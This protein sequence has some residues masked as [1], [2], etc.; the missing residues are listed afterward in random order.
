[1]ARAACQRHQLIDL[2]VEPG[3]PS[4]T[5]MR[6]RCGQ[7]GAYPRDR[8]GGIG[9]AANA[10]QRPRS[11][12][13]RAR[14]TN[15]GSPPADRP[16]RTAASGS[17]SAGRASPADAPRSRR[18]VHSAASW[19]HVR[20]SPTLRLPQRS[21]ND[22]DARGGHAPTAY[23]P[24]CRPRRGGRRRRDGCVANDAGL[25]RQLSR[26]CDTSLTRPWSACYVTPGT[27]GVQRLVVVVGKVTMRT[28]GAR[29]RCLAAADQ[30]RRQHAGAAGEAPGV[31][32]D[33]GA[34][35]RART[36]TARC[37]CRRTRRSASP[38]I[39]GGRSRASAPSSPMRFTS[40]P[41]VRSGFWTIGWLRRTGLR[42]TTSF[43][44]RYA[45]YLSARAA[46]SRWN[47]ATSWCAGSTRAPS[48]RWSARC[49]CCASCEGQRV[50]RRLVHWPRGVDVGVLQSRAPPRRGLPAA[51]ADLAV[52]R[53]RR[54]REEPGGF[55]V[56]AAA[57]H[58]GGGGRRAVARGA[59]AA[60][61][62]RR[63]ARLSLRRRPGGALRQ[64]R[65]LRVPVAHRDVRQR[66]ARG[67][68][69]GAAGRVGARPRAC[70]HR[71]GRR[72]R[73]DRRRPAG[74][75]H[76]RG[77]LLAR[78]RARE[79]RAPH[80]ERGPRGVSRPPGAAPAAAHRRA[81]A[82]R[83][84]AMPPRMLRQ[85]QLLERFKAAEAAAVPSG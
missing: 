38:A 18:C 72:Q 29:D 83:R 84:A 17:R 46:R 71:P 7:R 2:G 4:C 60:I 58:Q 36:R 12:D 63:V 49:R 67:D 32:R 24:R 41:R 27:I 57:R 85:P 81:R 78:Q 76:A 82:V 8:I 21:A 43:H 22:N 69:V 80:A 42:F 53:A 31:A 10:E 68:G 56:A 55:P 15:A 64:R 33:G 20:S 37:R 77:A 6:K 59:A 11:W 5:A 28:A 54:G 50:A 35:G 48:T 14:R 25:S 66:A 9:L 40:R 16:G 52:R 23:R 70:R 26:N 61:S 74:G 47:G 30:R 44:T 19:H 13:R 73:R 39:R 51:A 3:A 1:M 75:V 79:H 34:G 62:R 45:E 65:L